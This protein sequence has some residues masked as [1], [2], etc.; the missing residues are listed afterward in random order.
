MNKSSSTTE[1]KS[2]LVP[3]EVMFCRIQQISKKPVSSWGRTR[4]DQRR[5]QN[6]IFA[7]K[8]ATITSYSDV[9]GCQVDMLVNGQRIRAERHKAPSREPTKKRELAS[10]END[11]VRS[12]SREWTIV[13]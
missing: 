10:T 4:R 2:G 13:W 6:G 12:E 5:A 8:V 9:I 11:A 3:S 1:K 7:F